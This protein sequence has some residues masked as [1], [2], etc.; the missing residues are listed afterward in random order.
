MQRRHLGAGRLG[1]ALGVRL[2]CR[3]CGGGPIQGAG[4]SDEHA[5]LFEQLE[6]A[7]TCMNNFGR[8]VACGMISQYNLRPGNQYPIR[9]LMEI[10]AKR[11]TMRG[12]IVDDAN[13]GPRYAVG[14]QQKVQKW[15]SGGIFKATVD[16]T[17][18]I[19]NAAQGLVSLFEG[20]SFGKAVLEVDRL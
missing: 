2:R 1:R 13:M 17:K 3:C 10:I 6:A 7:I 4:T 11:L 20:R 12:F 18:G 5:E 9:N 14:H 8:I 16:V 19:D 15:L